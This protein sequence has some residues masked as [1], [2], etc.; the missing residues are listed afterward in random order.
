MDKGEDSHGALCGSILTARAHLLTDQGVQD[1]TL[2]V[3]GG[4]RS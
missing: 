4:W 3:L 2:V 1:R